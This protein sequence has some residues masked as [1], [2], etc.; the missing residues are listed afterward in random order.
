MPTCTV[1]KGSMAIATPKRPL[2][3]RGHDKHRWWN[4]PISHIFFNWTW[5]HQPVHQ[6]IGVALHHRSFVVSSLIIPT[7]NCQIGQGTAIWFV[8]VVVVVVVVG[9]G[10]GGGGFYIKCFMIMFT[11]LEFLFLQDCW[12]DDYVPNGLKY[13]KT[14]IYL[15]GVR[16]CLLLAFSQS[17][18][19]P[20]DN[21]ED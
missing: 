11:L 3:F 20:G 8:V 1:V 16:Y 2:S 13:T 21:L 4:D 6:Y 10:G 9:G 12:V 15:R 14:Y 18:F 7:K 17:L 5:N 19:W